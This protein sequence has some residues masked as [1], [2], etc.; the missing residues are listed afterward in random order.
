MI[1]SAEKR[2]SQRTR[3]TSRRPG[4]QAKAPDRASAHVAPRMASVRPR[5]DPTGPAPRPRSTTCRRVGGEGLSG[6]TGRSRIPS[7]NPRSPRLASIDPG[8]TSPRAILPGARVGPADSTPSCP[9]RRRFPLRG[10]P[11]SV[12]VSGKARSRGGGTV[13]VSPPVAFGVNNNPVIGESEP[14]TPPH[15]DRDN[16]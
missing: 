10:A 9:H 13:A 2:P 1:G 11:R 5:G 3:W 6:L 12:R 14:K 7:G 8:P 15:D 4:Q 16:R